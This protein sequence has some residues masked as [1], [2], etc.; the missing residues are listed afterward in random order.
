MFCSFARRFSALAVLALS[1]L[2][3]DLGFAVPTGVSLLPATTKGMISVPDVYVLEENWNKTQLGQMTL[4]PVMQPFVED[5]KRQFKEK[6]SN[7]SEKLGLTLDDLKGVPGGEVAVGLIQPTRT[8]ASLAVVVDVTGKAAE[9]AELMR[10]I[11]K[12]MTAKKATK[13]VTTFKGAKVTT[14]TL[15][16][17]PGEKVAKQAVFFTHNDIFSASDS[18]ATTAG[19]LSRMDGTAKDNLENLPAYKAIMQRVA[20]SAGEQAPEVRWFME[21][22]GYTE[23]SRIINPPKVKKTKKD[24]LKLLSEQGFREAIQGIGGYIHFY[25]DAKYEIIHRTAV[26]APAVPGAV[27][28]EK[29]KLAAR[30]LRFPNGGQLNPQAWVPRELSTYASFNLEIARAFEYSST[31]V[32]AYVGEPGTFED[33][34]KGLIEDPNGPR[35]DLRKDIVAHLDQRCTIIT[36]T[37]LPVTPKSER[38]VMAVESN[39]PVALAKAIERTMKSD[40]TVRKVTVA[41][42]TVWEIVQEEDENLPNLDIDSGIDPNGGN[43]FDPT[44]GGLGE[45]EEPRRKLPNSAVTVARGHLLVA[46]HI[47]FLEK[48]LVDFEAHET[49]ATNVDYARVMDELNVLFGA[50]RSARFFSRTEEEVRPTYELIRA[51]KMPE[52]ESV[53]GKLLNAFFGSGEEGEV[54]TQKIDGSQLPDFET[55]RRY[56]GPAGMEVISEDN[57]WFMVGVLLSR[58][59]PHAVNAT[60]RELR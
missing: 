14:Y 32:D 28:D 58:Q 47:D 50:T 12:N 54:R 41:G 40:P 48:V 44:G 21:P 11:D 36:D 3:A 23:A 8:T 60:D 19:I 37:S 33:V 35:I 24:M 20:V 39:N 1:A 16:K 15:V 30:M 6:W 55:V 53:L 18:S 34:I 43:A 51:G 59:L 57:G 17:K 2:S 31:F 56:F 45:D 26:H 49:L 29:Y 10:K 46:T 5:L 22:F 25:V 38:I 7:L 13:A 9:A 52:S 27:G 4:D 42:H